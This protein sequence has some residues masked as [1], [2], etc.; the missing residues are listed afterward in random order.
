[1]KFYE[2]EISGVWLIEAEPF[3]DSRGMFFRHFCQQEFAKN[4]LETGILQTNVSKNNTK[5]TLRGMH[6]QL[7]PFQEHKTMLCMSG[8]IYDII[9][10]LRP[11]SKTFLKW[12]TVELNSQ[13][14]LSLHIPAGCANGYL[15]LEDNTT[16]LYYMSE[17]YSPE[18]YRGFRYN[19]PLFGFKWPAEPLVISEKD[20]NYSDF[21]IQS[22][23]DTPDRGR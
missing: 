22:V 4:N 16:I 3:K 13:T 15:T 18:A 21:D 19:D 6:Y 10:D 5:L 11:E 1:M 14:P 12:I 7:K 9:V 17:F 20:S 2:Q 8:A 23:E